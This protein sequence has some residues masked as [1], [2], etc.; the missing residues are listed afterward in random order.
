MPS[1]LSVASLSKRIWHAY[2]A[3]GD[4]DPGHVSGKAITMQSACKKIRRSHS[5]HRALIAFTLLTAATLQ[6]AAG[7]SALKP[8]AGQSF[9]VRDLGTLPGN[10]SQASGINERGQVVGW[11]AVGG[12]EQALLNEHAFLFEHGVM[13]DLGMLPGGNSSTA[14]AINN[15]VQIVVYSGT[16]YSPWH[17]AIW[18][19]ER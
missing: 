19:R 13:T 1:L 4:G 14:S 5:F 2:S 6:P 11:S 17:A 10:T 18:T 9:D 16:P 15:R 3:V 8:S 12:N 7:Q